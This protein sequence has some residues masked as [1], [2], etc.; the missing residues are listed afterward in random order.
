[1]NQSKRNYIFGLVI[2]HP[3]S[4]PSLLEATTLD[5]LGSP[6]GRRISRLWMPLFGHKMNQK[7]T[8]RLASVR[9]IQNGV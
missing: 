2:C 6:N 8:T 1:M 3:Y 7:V 5:A 9:D 4:F